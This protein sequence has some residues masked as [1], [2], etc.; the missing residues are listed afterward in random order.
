MIRGR[1][2]VAEDERCDLR[3]GL[4]TWPA[5]FLIVG[6]DR[7]SDSDSETVLDEGDKLPKSR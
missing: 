1:E 3:T 7:M 5:L 4:T 2:G 6:R